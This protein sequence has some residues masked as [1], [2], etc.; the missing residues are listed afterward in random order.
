M[1][2]VTYFSFWESPQHFIV[3]EED[4]EELVYQGKNSQYKVVVTDADEDEPTT[5]S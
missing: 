3:P 1:K 2:R 4:V 5:F